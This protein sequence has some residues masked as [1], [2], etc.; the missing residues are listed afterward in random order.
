MYVISPDGNLVLNYSKHFLYE[1]DKPFC[2]A[3]DGFK[4]VQITT[5]QGCQLKVGVGIC[6]DINPYEFQ[7]Y[8]KYELATFFKGEDVDF[9]GLL[10]RIL[11]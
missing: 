8:S 10:K 7:D 1:S 6:M 9:I 3:G 11:R 5:K 2:R 4:T